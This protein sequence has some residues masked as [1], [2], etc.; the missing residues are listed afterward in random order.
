LRI[1]HLELFVEPSNL[2]SQRTAERAGFTFDSG[3]RERREIGGQITDVIGY[4]VKV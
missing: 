2:S 3:L 1:T 4:S